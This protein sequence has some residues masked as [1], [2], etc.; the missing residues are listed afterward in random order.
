MGL[1]T[2]RRNIVVLRS[3]GGPGG[4][5]GLTA[6][7]RRPASTRPLRRLL[8]ISCLLTAIGLIRV[9]GALRARWQPVLAG[10]ALTAIGVV[11]RDGAGGL[12]FMAGVLFL[13]AALVMPV[14]PAADRERL[15]TLERELAD[16]STPAERRDLEAILD[17]YPDGDTS[18]LRDILARQAMATRDHGVPGLGRFP[19]TPR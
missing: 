4:G 5:H 12:A 7:Q 9:A 19:S 13:Y 14:S 18:E 2:R 11:L 15:I 10:V 6:F 8:R 1:R 3:P 16:Y 17:R